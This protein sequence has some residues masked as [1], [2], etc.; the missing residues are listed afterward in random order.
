MKYTYSNKTAEKLFF[1]RAYVNTLQRTEVDVRMII[2]VNVDSSRYTNNF[3]TLT[4]NWKLV[5]L[6]HIR[7]GNHAA[8]SNSDVILAYWNLESQIVFIFLV[9]HPAV[10]F[11]VH[12]ETISKHIFCSFFLEVFLIFV[13]LRPLLFLDVQVALFGNVFDVIII[14]RRGLCF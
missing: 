7:V 6:T 8:N 10:V 14:S 13:R 2:Y 11:N 3:T 12:K 4:I 9:Q 1:I 5:V